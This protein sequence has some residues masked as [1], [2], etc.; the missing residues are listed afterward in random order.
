[1]LTPLPVSMPEMMIFRAPHERKSVRQKYPQTT[2]EADTSFGC[3]KNS[4]KR[5]RTKPILSR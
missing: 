4:N 1:M 5:T 2:N 3:N